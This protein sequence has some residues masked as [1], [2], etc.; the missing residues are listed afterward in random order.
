MQKRGCNLC[1]DY[2]DVNCMTYKH[3]K[4]KKNHIIISV[5]FSGTLQLASLLL[6]CIMISWLGSPTVQHCLSLLVEMQFTQ[7]HGSI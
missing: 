4:I 2:C 7:L 6:V 5:F 3:T 1:L